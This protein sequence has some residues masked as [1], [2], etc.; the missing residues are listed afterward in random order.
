[1]NDFVV[2]IDGK[3][4]NLKIQNDNQIEIDGKKLSVEF[5]KINNYLFLLK[6]GD[7]VYEVTTT[8]SNSE[9]YNFLVYGRFYEATVRTTLEEKANE[10]LS[11]KEKLSHHDN[12][13]APMPGMI[14]KVNKKVGDKVEIGEPVLILE[15]MKM[16]NELR[17]PASGIIKELLVKEGESVEKDTILLSID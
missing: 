17:S 2:T 15:A 13:K 11:Q 4:K 7:K 9:K 8:K 1:M 12:I 5:S 3:K 6:V 16:E 10:F 14:L